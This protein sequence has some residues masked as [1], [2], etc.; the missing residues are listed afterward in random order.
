MCC[1]K[2]SFIHSVNIYSAPTTWHAQSHSHEP[3]GQGPSCPYDVDFLMGL[4]VEE[5][6]DKQG[7]P[8]EG[9]GSNPGE[10][11]MQV[12]H[13]QIDFGVKAMVFSDGLDV[14]CI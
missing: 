4:G 7:D 11:R 13:F 14:G 5:W 10:L 2:D 3:N 9:G 12:I 8:W 6:W 1:V